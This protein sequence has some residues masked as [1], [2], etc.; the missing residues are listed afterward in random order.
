MKNINIIIKKEL[1]KVTESK[2]N[3]ILFEQ[4]KPVEKNNFSNTDNLVD[5]V[6]AAIDV[7]PGIG[8]LIS[9]GIDIT[10]GLTYI[11]RYFSAKNDEEKLSFFL[12]AFITFTTSFI[13]VG[14]NVINLTSNV[15][16]KQVLQK[17]PKEILLVGQ[18]LGLLKQTTIFLQKGKW[19]YSLLLLLTK[20]FKNT[21]VDVFI[22]V[23]NLLDDI[24]KKI[25]KKNPVQLKIFN[26]LINFKNILEELKKDIYTVYLISQK[27]KY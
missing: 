8:N 26:S 3:F 27:L 7:I 20:I 25:N 17:T 23:I 21:L 6:S 1:K 14:G 2:E 11:L 24:I 9:T 18:K 16:I 12:K 5:V 13:P 22:K 10:H 15:A 19:K 4:T